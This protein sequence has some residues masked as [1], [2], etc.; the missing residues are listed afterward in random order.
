MDSPA[1]LLS[2]NK[3]KTL[4]KDTG[5]N[6]KSSASE[7]HKS[8]HSSTLGLLKNIQQLGAA[9]TR[10]TLPGGLRSL[11]KEYDENY[12]TKQGI[13]AT[14]ELFYFSAINKP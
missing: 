4:I 6:L 13:Y 1:L 5:F 9:P 10:M 12:S 14:W 8:F 11:I 2:F 7:I 3:W